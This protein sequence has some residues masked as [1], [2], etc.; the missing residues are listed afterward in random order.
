MSARLV[1]LSRDKIECFAM[2]PKLTEAILSVAVSL[3]QRGMANVVRRLEADF[4]LAGTLLDGGQFYVPTSAAWLAW[5]DEAAQVKGHV[6]ASI[7]T[8]FDT[9][10]VVVSQAALLAPD[11]GQELRD[12]W[13]EAFDAW[14]LEQGCREAVMM[15]PHDYPAVWR[16]YRFH[17]WRAVYRREL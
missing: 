6:A 7:E 11:I 13:S 8:L 9:R 4:V 17:H 1:R 2:L 10:L 15:T 12:Q 14:M 16:P 3:E 5:D